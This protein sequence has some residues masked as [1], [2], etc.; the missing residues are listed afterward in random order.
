M[1]KA[2][3]RALE[4]QLIELPHSQKKHFLNLLNLKRHPSLIDR[5]ILHVAAAVLAHKLKNGVNPQVSNVINARILSVAR[6]LMHL[7]VLLYLAF[8]KK[9]SGSIISN[10]CSIVCL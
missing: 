3:I 1:S 8:A 4:A 10:V 9:I 2:D 7:R 6:R 5:Q